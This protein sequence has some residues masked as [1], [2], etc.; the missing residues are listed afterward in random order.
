MTFPVFWIIMV[1]PPIDRKYRLVVFDWDGTLA[2][3]LQQIV[4][5]M[6]HAIDLHG[7][8]RPGTGEIRHG[9]GLGLGELISRLFPD[10]E[11]EIQLQV[12]KAYRE[13]YL[14][15]AADVTALFPGVEET[16]KTL[17]E[18]GYYLAVATGKSRRGLERSLEQTGL[19]EY[20]HAT[21]CADETFSKPHPQMLRE[22]ME[23]LDIPP[24]K[25]LMVGD[26]EHDMQ[27]A[28]NAGVSPLAVN[29]GAQDSRRLLE[30]N[31]VMVLPSL[32][33]ITP[34]LERQQELDPDI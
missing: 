18:T 1:R 21:H 4:S 6:E 14:A 22:I 28:K 29:Y 7:L 25:T 16:I 13:R 26:S 27:M 2:D 30:F 3:S 5:A 23:L 33:E 17:H 11:P 10:L 15:T 20:F 12:A 19:R 9:I 32:P 34:W 24:E 31:P 8:A